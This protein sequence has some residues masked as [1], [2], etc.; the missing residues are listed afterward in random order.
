M[1]NSKFWY[2]V[3]VLAVIG[4]FHSFYKVGGFDLLVAMTVLWLNTP[5]DVF[6]KDEE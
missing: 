2:F 4:S 3:M 6:G 5:D 1:K